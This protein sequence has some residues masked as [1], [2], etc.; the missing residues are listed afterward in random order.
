MLSAEGVG[1]AVTRG[2]ESGKRQVSDFLG[3]DFCKLSL[4]GTNLRDGWAN[5]I[6]PEIIGVDQFKTIKIDLLIR[7]DD[8]AGD[9]SHKERLGRQRPVQD[10]AL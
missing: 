5:Q 6:G 9:I 10:T 8:V 3:V 2:T 4:N 7:L 1:A